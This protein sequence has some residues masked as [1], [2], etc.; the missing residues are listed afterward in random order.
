M[1]PTQTYTKESDKKNPLF[2]VQGVVFLCGFVW[3]SAC[4]GWGDRFA[5][6]E[7]WRAD[8]VMWDE[9]LLVLQEECTYCHSEPLKAGAP[10]PLENYAQATHWIERI[11]VRVF[12]HNDMPPGGI[13][14]QENYEVLLKWIEKE[15]NQPGSTWIE[16]PDDEAGVESGSDMVG[17][18]GGDQGGNMSDNM[19]GD[20]ADLI[21]WEKDILELF[22]IYCNN[23]HSDPPTG[24]APF[25]LLEYE[26]AKSFLDRI[27]IRTVE[28]KNMPPGGVMDAEDL[29]KIADWISNGAP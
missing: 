22:T 7:L 4:S 16:E 15:R 9:A 25:P 23:C 8:R 10:I 24:G 26:Q 17:S 6:E 11:W 27:Q 29:Q 13:Q 12:Q 2:C 14:D 20:Q 19:G 18:M 28:Q 5:Q 21:T 1:T 3:M